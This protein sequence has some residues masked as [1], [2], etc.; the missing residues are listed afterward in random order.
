MNRPLTA[1][2]L[3]ALGLAAPMASAQE[4]APPPSN[5]PSPAEKNPLSTTTVPDPAAKPGSGTAMPAPEKSLA[6]PSAP[7]AP[8]AGSSKAPALQTLV[9][10]QADL[11]DVDEVSLPAKPVAILSGTTRKENA[12][13]DLKASFKRI[14]DDLAKASIKPSGRPLA[15]FTGDDEEALQYQAMIPIASAPAQGA[16]GAD[17]VRFGSTPSGKGF[18]YRHSGSYDAI[19]NTYGILSTYLDVKDIV[20]QDLF[21]EEYLTDLTDDAD[22]KLE[23]NI[24]ALRK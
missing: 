11:G 13:A 3:L 24:Y 19:G 17:G 8:P 21:V 18:R 20:V 6:P 10:P 22:E 7:G 14:E 15:V 4:K 16:A 12:V 23:V 5:A 9:P 2:I 1:T